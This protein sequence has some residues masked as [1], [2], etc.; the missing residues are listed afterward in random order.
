MIFRRRRRPAGASL[1]SI[2]VVGIG[3]Y[4]TGAGGWLTNRVAQL[5][6]A[7][8]EALPGQ[9]T[10]CNAVKK[11]AGGAVY[12]ANIS[13]NML[14]KTIGKQGLMGLVKNQQTASGYGNASSGLALPSFSFEQMAQQFHLNGDIER[15]LQKGP[16]IGQVDLGQTSSIDALKTAIEHYVVGEQLAN[17]ASNYYAPQDALKWHE[18]G[19]SIGAYGIGSQ[20]ALGN[21]YSQGLGGQVDLGRAKAYYEY[22][23]QSLESLNTSDDADA[24]TLLKGLGVSPDVIQKE[25]NAQ[26]KAIGQA[27]KPQ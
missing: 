8:Y 15:L 22:A 16:S 4:A 12:M 23:L 19:A 26:L 6:A 2:I 21:A 7:C 13:G 14:D 20:L 10:V 24:K 1:T 27:T 5:P 25:V 18:Q 9:A 17:P 3:L 11:L